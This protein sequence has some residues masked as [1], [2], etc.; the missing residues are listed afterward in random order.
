MRTFLSDIYKK[1]A[2]PNASG[3]VYVLNDS[4][5]KQE[6]FLIPINDMLNTSWISDLFPK[7]EF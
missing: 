3:R 6:E 5:I 2:K 1:I 4:Q 7:E